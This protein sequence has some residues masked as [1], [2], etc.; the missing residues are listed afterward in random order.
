MQLLRGRGSNLSEIFSSFYEEG[1]FPCEIW[2]VV[3]S[4][5]LWCVSSTCFYY[6]AGGMC[7]FV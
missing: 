3:L 2:V 5:T 6:G 1:D 4:M 7:D